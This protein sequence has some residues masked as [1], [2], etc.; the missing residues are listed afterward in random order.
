MIIRALFTHFIAKLC[1]YSLICSIYNYTLRSSGEMYSLLH[2]V[3]VSTAATKAIVMNI[4]FIS[5]KYDD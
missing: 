1:R 4:C 3:P 5:Q 2:D